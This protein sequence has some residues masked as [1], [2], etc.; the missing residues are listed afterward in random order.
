MTLLYDALLGEILALKMARDSLPSYCHIEVLFEVAI[1]RLE[2]QAAAVLRPSK[3][4][5][6]KAAAVSLDLGELERESMNLNAVTR[7]AR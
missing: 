4:S 7:S 5:G 1:L 2:E 6:Q 3:I